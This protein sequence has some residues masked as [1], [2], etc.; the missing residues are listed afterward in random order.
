ML[1][2][3]ATA[4]PIQA[5]VVVMADRIMALADQESLS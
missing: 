3:A 4:P 1:G 5:V 2:L